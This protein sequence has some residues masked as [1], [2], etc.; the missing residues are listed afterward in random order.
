MKSQRPFFVG[1]IDLESIPLCLEACFSCLSSPEF[2][3]REGS[4]SLERPP[5]SDKPSKAFWNFFESVGARIAM[6]E[7]VNPIPET[8]E[9]ESLTHGPSSSS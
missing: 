9:R 7:I 3:F 2:V 4:V 6:Y 1:F 8:Q 5:G